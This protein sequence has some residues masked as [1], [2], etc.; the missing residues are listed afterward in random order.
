MRTN[1]ARFSIFYDTNSVMVVRLPG[2]IEQC[3][4]NCF[5]MD[6]KNLSEHIIFGHECKI[7]ANYVLFGHFFVANFRC[8]LIFQ[9]V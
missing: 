8:L 9:F 6:E 7:F 1:I 4:S 5:E 2:A 3:S